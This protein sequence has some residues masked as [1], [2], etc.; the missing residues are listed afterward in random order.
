MKSHSLTER[1]ASDQV[2]MIKMIRSHSQGPFCSLPCPF[3]DG[4]ISSVSTLVLRTV[5]SIRRGKMLSVMCVRV[6][7]LIG[8]SPRAYIFGNSRL[9]R[10]FF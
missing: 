4:E 6:Y 3:S 10:L 2:D 1:E 7:D 9:S 8:N 5:Q